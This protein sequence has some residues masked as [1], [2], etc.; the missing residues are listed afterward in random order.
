MHGARACARPARA[1][2]ADHRPSP[3]TNTGR[4]G[5]KPRASRSRPAIRTASAPAARCP[6]PAR[7]PNRGGVGQRFEVEHLRALRV[8]HLQQPA[9]AR[10]G[11]AAD[12][13]VLELCR[14]L[15][16][17]CDHGAPVFAVATFEH[18]HTKADLVEHDGERT[19]RCRR[20]SSRRAASSS[21]GPS[22][23]VR[24]ARRCCVPP[25][26]RPVSSR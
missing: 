13:A 15:V 23:R 16:Q 11:G 25:A 22:L 9:S 8:Q 6:A 18:V 19:A 17:R 21:A 24:C 10:T 5:S 7:A 20:A 12:H 4:A 2:R 1:A 3:S 14:Q 26:R